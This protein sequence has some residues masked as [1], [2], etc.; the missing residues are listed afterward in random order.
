VPRKLAEAIRLKSA[1]KPFKPRLD[2]GD[3]AEADALVNGVQFAAPL[4]ENAAFTLE[5][6]ADFKD[7][8]GRTLRNATAFR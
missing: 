2:G 7:A 4:A 3:D 5:L 8:S 6:P 1:T